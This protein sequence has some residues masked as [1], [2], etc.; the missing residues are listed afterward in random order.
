[1]FRKNHRVSFDTWRA[2]P[3]RSGQLSIQTSS[4]LALRTQIWFTPEA[5]ILDAFHIIADLLWCWQIFCRLVRVFALRVLII[6]GL[7]FLIVNLTNSPN[8][9][10]A[11]INDPPETKID[12]AP[13]V[14]IDTKIIASQAPIFAWPVS[15]TYISSYFSSFHRG[16][17]IPNQYSSPIKPLA[18]GSVVFAGWETTGF[19]NTVV[20][21]HNTGYLSRYSHLSAIDVHAGQGV[22]RDTIL[23]RIGMTGVATGPHLHFEVY[24]DGQPIN[25]LTILP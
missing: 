2:L 8:S 7:I 17:D 20:V 21:A 16:I 4:A 10:T 5:I 24:K 6:F 1:M 15:K 9:A 13:T 25:P 19:G 23:G 12:K 18:A 14:Q 3:P 11:D 22:G